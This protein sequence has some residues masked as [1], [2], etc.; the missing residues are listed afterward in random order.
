MVW[1]KARIEGARILEAMVRERDSMSCGLQGGVLNDVRN[2]KT[3]VGF[4][5]RLKYYYL[6]YLWGKTG[7]RRWDC[8]ADGDRETKK[9]LLLL[10]LP[11]DA[12]A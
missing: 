1:R 6:L 3:S 9:C 2:V 5:R 8:D 11:R 10:V 4:G 7:G 12:V